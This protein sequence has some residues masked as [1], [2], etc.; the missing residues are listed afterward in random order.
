[1]NIVQVRFYSIKMTKKNLVFLS[2]KHVLNPL[3][4]AKYEIR[5]NNK[6]FAEVK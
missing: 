3:G 6:V 2:V 1:M 5:K 4:L